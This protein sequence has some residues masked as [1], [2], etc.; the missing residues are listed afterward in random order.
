MSHIV[1]EINEAQCTAKLLLNNVTCGDSTCINAAE[2]RLEPDWHDES[3]FANFNRNV[4]RAA[5]AWTVAAMLD[6]DTENRTQNQTRWLG[7]NKSVMD[8]DNNDQ[9]LLVSIVY[10]KPTYPKQASNLK[11]W[12]LHLQTNWDCL[13]L[14]TNG[15][16]LCF[17]WDNNYY[18][19]LTICPHCLL[20]NHFVFLTFVWL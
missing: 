4:A 8:T 17:D 15:P 2:W 20:L 1:S 19:T 12:G 13:K 9:H 11:V 5:K 3:L 16:G 7:R 10:T 14:L 18:S 6:V